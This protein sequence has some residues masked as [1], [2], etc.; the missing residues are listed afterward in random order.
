MEH[1]PCNDFNES[2][3]SDERDFLQDEPNPHYDQELADRALDEA[4]HELLIEEAL[5]RKNLIRESQSD[6]ASEVDYVA[7]QQR[8]EAARDALRGYESGYFDR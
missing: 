2:E 4:H 6:F 5:A 1:D 3:P 7:A 8:L